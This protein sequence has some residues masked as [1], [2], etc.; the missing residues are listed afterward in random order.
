MR[1][2]TVFGP[3]I[4]GPRTRG[5]EDRGPRQAGPDTSGPGGRSSQ[6][7]SRRGAA[8][9]GQGQGQGTDGPSTARGG[10]GRLA[11]RRPTAGAA[12]ARSNAPSLDS[13]LR[14]PAA[15]ALLAV[16]AIHLP[17]DLAGLRAGDLAASV[18]SA[19]TALCLVLAALLAVR[20]TVWIW[21]AGATA[22]VGTVA[23]HSVA[24]GL[25]PVHLLRDSLGRS[26]A[27]S[28]TM[29]LACAA[30]AAA[31]AGSALLRRQKPKVAATDA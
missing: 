6:N 15:V 2:V 16:A 22:A 14:R 10:L 30:V 9:Q 31:L 25:G 5:P 26:F 13:A 4:D 7:R 17:T 20:D 24:A 29:V 12:C 8:R 1:P 23:L 27:G 28:T 3:G 21:A 19:I 18:S 11:G